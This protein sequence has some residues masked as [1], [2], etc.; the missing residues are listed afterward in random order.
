MGKVVFLVDLSGWACTCVVFVGSR[1]YS[2]DIAHPCP[3][4]YCG[5]TAPGGAAD[6]SSSRAYFMCASYAF[7]GW[8]RAGPAAMQHR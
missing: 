7:V 3:S 8:V 2:W 4:F 1:C 6:G 5:K